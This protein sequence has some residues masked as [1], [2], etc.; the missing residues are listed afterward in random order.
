M[1]EADFNLLPFSEQVFWLLEAVYACGQSYAHRKKL[2]QGAGIIDRFLNWV[3]VKAWHR[4]R[5]REETDW[6][7]ELAHFRNYLNSSRLITDFNSQREGFPFLPIT[8][9]PDAKGRALGA[10]YDVSLIQYLIRE[11]RLTPEAAFEYPLALAE[12]NY[13][14]WLERE[15]GLRILNAFEM[16]FEEYCREGNERDAKLAA[17]KQAQKA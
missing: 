6:A 13:L 8:A 9:S 2:E 3:K 10:P 16:E 4:R 12:V 11:H 15:G 1:P 17:E 5:K 7:L 14:A